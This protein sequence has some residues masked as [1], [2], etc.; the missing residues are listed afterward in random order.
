METGIFRRSNTQK[1]TDDQHY[2]SKLVRTETRAARLK[3]RAPSPIVIPT[4]PSPNPK[5]DLFLAP[6]FAS[7]TFS[8]SIQE[9]HPYQQTQEPQYPQQQEADMPPAR[10]PTPAPPIPKRPDVSLTMGL[11]MVNPAGCTSSTTLL[12]F[13]V[14]GDLENDSSLADGRYPKQDRGLN[15]GHDRHSSYEY[16]V[17]I[18]SRTGAKAELPQ[19]HAHKD[20][21]DI[22]GSVAELRQTAAQV[23]SAAA[24]AAS[25]AVGT[26]PTCRRSSQRLQDPAPVLDEQRV[27]H[28]RQ[29]KMLKRSSQVL[30]GHHH[31]HQQDTW[32]PQWRR[33]KN[34]YDLNRVSNE[35][36][37]GSETEKKECKS[38]E[39]TKEEK[40]RL[41]ELLQK[42]KRIENQQS[43]HWESRSTLD[44]LTDVS[45]Q[46]TNGGRDNG[47][48]RTQMHWLDQPSGCIAPGV[49]LGVICIFTLA[50]NGI[51]GTLVYQASE[52]PTDTDLPLLVFSFVF[53]IGGSVFFFGFIY[54]AIFGRSSS[55][56]A[57]H[58]HVTRA[59]YFIKVFHFLYFLHALLTFGCM[60]SWLGLNKIS[61]GSWDRMYLK[62]PQNSALPSTPAGGLNFES[63]L[64]QDLDNP[65]WWII[66]PCIW[67]AAFASIWAIQLYFWVC[68]VAYGRRIGM[69]RQLARGLKL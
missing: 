58:A 40:G 14:L 49:M 9:Q 18:N 59:P 5:S 7:T 69:K 6:Q 65:D 38:G 30:L 44:S 64:A 66:N 21:T 13:D 17:P 10:V 20:E 11:G 52:F 60:M 68:L 29:E 16:G 43:Q 48:T 34:R 47:R 46:D 62:S 51:L 32:K 36:S 24:L 35:T 53:I 39:M 8:T 37:V 1:E 67:V 50:Y 56:L 3:D 19:Y 4:Y 55:R 25:V 33:S 31:L 61:T 22:G 41:E 26:S 54:L 12:E 27:R 23:A 28:S 63:L 57:N 42:K 15:T 2:L 45:P